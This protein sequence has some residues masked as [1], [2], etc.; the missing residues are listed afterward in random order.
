[1]DKYTSHSVTGHPHTRMLNALGDTYENYAQVDCE[2]MALASNSDGLQLEGTHME[3]AHFGLE[4]PWR[5]DES[6]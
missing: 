5:L 6:L 2:K 3:F 4:A 1:V